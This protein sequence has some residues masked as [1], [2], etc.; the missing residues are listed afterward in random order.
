MMACD[1]LEVCAGVWVNRLKCEERLRVDAARPTFQ[2]LSVLRGMAR[3]RGE[4]LS[5]GHYTVEAR[6]ISSLVKGERSTNSEK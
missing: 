4:V 6:Q 1:R 3:P 2:D 5:N